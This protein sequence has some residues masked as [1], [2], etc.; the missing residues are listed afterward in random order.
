[1]KLLI[2]LLAA[3]CWVFVH[4]APAYADKP[5]EGVLLT[6]LKEYEAL[7]E[8]TYANQ[9]FAGAT[10]AVASVDGQKALRVYG[11]EATPKTRFAIGSITKLFS[12]IA[13]M[14]SVEKG[15]LDLDAPVNSYLKT[16][17]IKIIA[18]R[19]VT[20][21]HLLT[22]SGGFDANVY[23][24]EPKGQARSRQTPAT[25]ARVYRP[26]IKPGQVHQYDNYGVGL[27]GVVLSEV[28]GESYADILR[29]RI[30]EPLS[31]NAT[32]VGIPPNSEN[33]FPCYTHRT[34]SGWQACPKH[35]VLPQSLEA[36]GAIISSASDMAN[37][38]SMLLGEGTFNGWR[39]LSKSSF[40]KLVD[41]EKERIRPGVNGLGFI[42]EEYGGAQS[43]A[44]GHT[45]GIRGF[46]SNLVVSPKDGLAVFV[47]VAGAVGAPPLTPGGQL[48][49]GIDRSVLPTGEKYA[50]LRKAN[51]I[52]DLTGDPVAMKQNTKT[53]PRL[54][55][56]ELAGQYSTPH[57]LAEPTV[58]WMER[59]FVWFSGRGYKVTIV[60]DNA[61]SVV[62]MG[63]YERCANGLFC[64][65]E[66]GTV[67]AFGRR[68]DR[69][70]M[71]WSGGSDEF[72]RTDALSS[73]Q[74]SFAPLVALAAL[75]GYAVVT[76]QMRYAPL[77][78]GSLLLVMSLFVELEFIA[79]ANHNRIPFAFSYLWR[80]LAI[81]SLCWVV[82]ESVLLMT[83]AISSTGRLININLSIMSALGLIFAALT[84][85]VA[86][87]LE[88]MG[89]V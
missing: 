52:V 9:Q 3:C 79:L 1:M 31:M 41:M 53:Y 49:S 56:Y 74:L 60:D 89:V 36:A 87:P 68:G 65:G 35:E 14:Q 64:N 57:L 28:T 71:T 13:T 62:G 4:T 66:D 70:V 24:I 42:F 37:F 75:A 55:T 73:W 6:F 11:P 47:S 25:L 81:V 10:F 76:R 85:L 39:L 38:V 59:L 21:R 78:A 16:F 18:D 2:S 33:L 83:R 50:L 22:H 80:A 72:Y 34:A 69:T 20:I 26:V 51:E 43:G 17:Q 84:G 63:R 29:I 46:R 88:W 45:G 5:M 86:G 77:I 7:A 54:E 40:T 82:Y 58:R 30:F 67:L 44:F 48:L 19:P 61:V 27:L 15:E 32:E 12:A 8:R 23:G